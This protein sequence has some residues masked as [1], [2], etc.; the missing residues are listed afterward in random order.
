M[1]NP[2]KDFINITFSDDDQTE[3]TYQIT[4]ASGKLVLSGNL[5]AGQRI[6]ISDL[7]SG[8]YIV[9]VGT[10]KGLNKIEKLIIE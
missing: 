4:D 8:F 7:S 3:R 2:A 5:V 6:D 10:S 9:Q 1:Y